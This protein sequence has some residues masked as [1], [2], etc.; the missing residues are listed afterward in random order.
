MTFFSAAGGGVEIGEAI[1]REEPEERGAVVGAEEP[2]VDVAEQRAEVE[3]GDQVAELLGRGVGEDRDDLGL[4]AAIG[5]IG[6]QAA[7]GLE[8]LEGRGRRVAHGVDS[9]S[10][11]FPRRRRAPRRPAP[12][13]GARI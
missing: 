3:A 11:S 10:A 1:G 2:I 12:T 8:L 13:A 4:L 7:D 9:F 6:H 5:V